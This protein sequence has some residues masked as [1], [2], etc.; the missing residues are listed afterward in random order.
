MEGPRR[1]SENS[2][3][4]GARALEGESGEL[5]LRLSWGRG[6]RLADAIF[7]KDTILN[8]NIPKD[9]NSKL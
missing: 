4:L 3:R 6:S 1:E 8:V 9:K 7:P 2:C 5:D